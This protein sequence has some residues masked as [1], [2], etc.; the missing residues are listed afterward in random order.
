MKNLCDNIKYQILS[1]A[2]YGWLAYHRN[3][4]T[5]RIHLIGLINFERKDEYIEE[6][7]EQTEP[8]DEANNAKEK[9]SLYLSTNKKIDD[10]LWSEWENDPEEFTKNTLNFY[11]IVYFN[12]IENDLRKKVNS[13]VV[14]YVKCFL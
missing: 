14:F 4:K 9:S 2:F 6:C 1:R 7:G 8:R 12:G 11:R 13:S 10:N 3:L 5:V